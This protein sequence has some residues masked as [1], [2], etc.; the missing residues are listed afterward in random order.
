[1]KKILIS[2]SIIAAAA[3]VIVGATT[4]F[5]SDTETSTGNTFTA[6]AIDLKIDNTS[7]ATDFTIPDFQNPTGAIVASPANTWQADDLTNQLFFYFADL[8][9]GDVGED[10][11]S[12]H[13]N[14]NDAYA[15]MNIKLTEIPEND[16][17]EAE[18]SAGDSSSDTTGEL[19]N[20]LYFAFW[21]DD[22]DNVFETNET[23]FS[24]GL[25]KDLFEGNY[26]SL[27]DSQ[28]NVL[29]GTPGPIQGGATYNIGKVWCF[30]TLTSNAVTAGTGVNPTVATGFICNG[31]PVGNLS[32]TDGIKADV[33]FYA[34]QSRNNSEFTC[35]SLNPKVGAAN[36]VAG[37]PT[38]NITVDDSIVGDRDTIQEGVNLANAGETVCVAEGNYNEFTVNKALTVRGLTD[39]EGLNA[40]IVKPSNV[41]ATAL[42]LVTASNVTI[43]GLKFNG[44]GLSIAGQAAGVQVSPIG[45]SLSNVNIT[46]NYVKSIVAA[47]GYAAKGI[48]WFTDTNSG[49]QLSNSSIKHNTIDKIGAID[50]GGYGVQTVGSMSNVAI[51]NNT[52]SN[53]MGAWGAGIAVDTKDTSLTA[54]SGNTI[55]LNQI[56]NNAAPIFAVQ[57][58]NRVNAA[59]VGVHQNNIDTLLYGGGNAVLGTEGTVN[60]ENNWFG[61]ATPAVGT[62]VFLVP[63][64]NVV[65]FDPAAGSAFLLN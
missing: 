3:A 48:Q 7:Y 9:P 20:E 65:D 61:T 44:D 24:Q 18:V 14:N 36:Y 8:K 54:M 2:V 23:I 38:C 53:T 52:I 32:Q 42:A 1:M 60:A 21:K 57:I 4:A 47:T 10:T 27:A 26:L 50:K 64:T 59:G 11:I 25:A 58:E 30:G 12:L 15:C 56:M 35:E 62:D 40:A 17:N 33:S 49:L 29:T 51:E 63:A 31:A 46:Y 41:A 19:Q 43:T 22:G 37:T 34:V 28:I 16:A 6:G 5:F 55:S 13:V 45:S 39:P